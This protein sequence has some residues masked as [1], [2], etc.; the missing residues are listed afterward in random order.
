MHCNLRPPEP[1]QPFPAFITTSCQVWCRRT[2]AFPYYSVFAADTLRCDLDS[3]PVTL[4][5]DL[6]YLQRMWR[7]ETLYQIWTQSN[8]SQQ[9]YCDFSVSPYDLEYVLS[10]ALGSGI[11]FTKFDLRQ[12]IRASSSTCLRHDEVATQWSAQ[13]RSTWNIGSRCAQEQILSV[14]N[15]SEIEHSPA[16][17]LIILQIFAHVIT[18]WPWPLTSWPWT[19]KAIQMSCI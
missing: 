12:L 11:I 10:V 2:Y 5:F 1:R 4:T 18:L 6:E 9:S 8:N 3:D 19:F 14:Q 16:E 7:D 13:C 15:L 17:L